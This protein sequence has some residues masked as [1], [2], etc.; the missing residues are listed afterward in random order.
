MISRL[1]GKLAQPIETTDPEILAHHRREAAARKQGVRHHQIISG[2]VQNRLF[3]IAERNHFV[4]DIEA[5]WSSHHERK[6]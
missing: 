4:P 2:A 6:D 1:L 3:A 5:T